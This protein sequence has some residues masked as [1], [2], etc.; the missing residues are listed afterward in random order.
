MIRAALG[1]GANLG[2]RLAALQSA[3]DLICGA[4]AVR[5]I[6]VSSVHETDPV[7]G[8]EQPDYY[9][10]VLVIE[11]SLT[12]TELL[13]LAHEA[14]SG[15]GRTREIRWGPRTLDVDILAFGELES[16]DPV[17]TLPHPRAAQRAF[18]LVPWS[19]VDPDFTLAGMAQTV[20]EL[21]EQ[22]TEDDLA[23]VRVVGEEFLRLPDSHTLS[24]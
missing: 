7:G 18:V 4:E 10:A 16:S 12:P 6:A 15:R 23:S 2:D 17:L 13:D 3:V 22:L 1:L 21:R 20:S 11:T 19:E 24:V 9:N 5:G 14:E 8:P